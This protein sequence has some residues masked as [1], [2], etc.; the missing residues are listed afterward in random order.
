MGRKPLKRG[1]ISADWIVRG[2]MKSKNGWSWDLSVRHNLGN[3]S[4]LETLGFSDTLASETWEETEE[5]CGAMHG[6]SR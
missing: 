2:N 1:G 4:R 3:A 6:Y 5:R